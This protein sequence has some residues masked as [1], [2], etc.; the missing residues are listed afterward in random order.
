MK[1]L[2]LTLFV[3][4]ICVAKA[5]LQAPW[6]E[7]SWEKQ[8]PSKAGFDYL[9]I[10]EAQKYVFAK[11][12][13]FDTN[14]LLI[15]RNGRLIYE[16]Y[17]NG[18]SFDKPHRLWSISKSVTNALV[19]ATIQ[20]Q[21]L[22]LK[23]LIA[24]QYPE[25]A[26]HEWKRKITVGNL[27]QMSSGLDWNEGY[28]DNISGSDVLKALYGEKNSDIA[29]FVASLEPRCQVDV[30]FNYSSGETNLLMGYL[31]KSMGESYGLYPWTHLFYKLGITTATWEQDQSGTFIGSS[32][33]YMTPRDLARIG[34][35]YL[36]EGKTDRE[37]IIP[38]KFIHWSLQL[39]PAFRKTKLLPDQDNKGYG[40]GWW[41]NQE[42]EAKNLPRPYPNVPNNAFFGLGHW[43]QVLAVLPSHNMII[44]RHGNDRKGKIDVNKM[45]SM[46]IQAMEQTPIKPKQL[47]A[48]SEDK[49]MQKEIQDD[50][51]N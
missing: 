14:A 49:E 10:Y 44:V 47:P 25:M 38:S 23:D 50:K 37:Q 18:Y 34:L 6:P 42:I 27:L 3:L 32:Y 51:N 4:N 35:L 12:Q 48:T 11:D 22:R 9:K 45:V 36:R 28:E 21:K 17:E 5:A 8:D 31:K 39:A 13:G 30:C 15:I 19:G 29:S 24:A 1:L 7:A 41:L 40:A 43:G 46:V 20:D 26:K 16:K 2:Y 33:V